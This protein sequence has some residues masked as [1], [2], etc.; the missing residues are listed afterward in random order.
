MPKEAPATPAFAV[1]SVKVPS[2]LFLYSALRTG[3]DGFQKSLGPLFTRKISIHPSLSKSRKAQPGPSVSGRNR[4][5]DIA[6]SWTHVIPDE[7]DGTST[8][9]D[10]CCPKANGALN[11][12]AAP[13][14][15]VSRTQSLR[16]SFMQSV[17][18]MRPDRLRS[19]HFC[20]RL[21]GLRLRRKLLNDVALALPV[22]RPL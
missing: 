1:T 10:S 8:N 13:A 2:R 4:L 17:C 15:E 9:R 19:L 11:K 16:V 6:F 22:F 14:Q 12:L 21:L 7:D 18:T 3:F 20:S 5:G